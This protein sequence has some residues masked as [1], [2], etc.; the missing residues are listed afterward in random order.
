MG[1][2]E[3]LVQATLWSGT[4]GEAKRPVPAILLSR[5]PID[6][7]KNIKILKFNNLYVQ[8]VGYLTKMKI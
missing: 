6:V 3:E 8:A 7:P 5:Q 1:P 4:G 2:C